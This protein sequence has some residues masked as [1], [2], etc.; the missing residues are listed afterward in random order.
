MPSPESTYFIDTSFHIAYF[1]EDDDNHDD[2]RTFMSMIY[3][4]SRS[5]TFVTTN[6]VFQETMNLVHRNM[7]IGNLHER[8]MAAMQL[9]KDIIEYTEVYA[10]DPDMLFKSFEL[11]VEKNQEGYEWGFVDCSSFVFIREIRRKKHG[12]KRLT[13]NQALAFD[14]HYREAAPLFDFNVLP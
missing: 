10:I 12:S 6:L 14:D 2:A 3:E 8:I 11:F 5:P 9:G 13:I 4:T 7:R 1:F